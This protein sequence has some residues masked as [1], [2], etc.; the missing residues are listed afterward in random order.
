MPIH[1]QNR[2]TDD[3]NGTHMDDS[4]E[5]FLKSILIREPNIPRGDNFTTLTPVTIQSYLSSP[6][7]DA[8]GNVQSA[9]TRQ[10]TS[11]TGIRPPVFQ[12]DDVVVDLLD[13]EL[14]G[15]PKESYIT[16]LIRTTDSSADVISTYRL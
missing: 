6:P 13:R 16:T 11:G 9:Q 1:E 2:F 8:D 15:Q 3:Y 7:T 4:D 14:T 5:T 10:V 12:I